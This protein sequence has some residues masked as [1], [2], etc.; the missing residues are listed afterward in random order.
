[1][2]TNYIRGNLYG[3]AYLS[4]AKQ[5]EFNFMKPMPSEIEESY[6]RV[7]NELMELIYKEKERKTIKKDSNSRC[8]GIQI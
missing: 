6:H 7:R 3:N 5:L 2:P 4:R 1:M 8:L